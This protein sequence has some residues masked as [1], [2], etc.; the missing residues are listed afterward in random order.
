MPPKSET[1]LASEYFTPEVVLVESL[2]FEGGPQ[3][4]SGPARRA[5]AAVAARIR[6]LF[7]SEPSGEQEATP[8][9][10]GCREASLT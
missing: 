2:F 6:D 5:A 1:D 9:R 8:G 3:A 10:G 7:M 4:A